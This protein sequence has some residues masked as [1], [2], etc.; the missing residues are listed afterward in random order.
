MSVRLTLAD[1]ELIEFKSGLTPGYS[2]PI[3]K[4]AS[5]ISY[6]SNLAQ[7][8]V[9]EIVGENY[10]IRFIIGKFLKKISSKDWINDQGLYCYFMLKNGIRKNIAS[11]GKIHVRQDQHFCFFTV[12]VDCSATFEKNTEF[13]AL[14][15]FY[16]PK[17]LQELTPFFPELKKLMVS[18]EGITLSEKPCWSLPSM[19][20]IVN[21]IF[22]CPFDEATRQFYLD[23]KVREL[24]YQLLENTFRRNILALNFTAFETARI[25][26][27]RDILKTYINKKPPT[28]K[29]LSRQVAINEFKLKKGFRQYFNAGIFEW[30]QEQKMQHAKE[31]LLTTN[32]P[33]KDICSLVGYP[34][35]TNFITAFRRR[36]GM[37]PGSLRRQ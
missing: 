8:V 15:F 7:L 10:S 16:S 3:L 36:F 17:M 9:Q 35:I 27:A 11:I 33:I 2:G 13:S 21:Q 14:D 25:H 1:G 29:S 37:T 18:T 23:L 19:K 26:E 20:E 5:I 6:K 32:K 34:R 4:G 22:N 30:L 24:L 12:P 28:I 31:L